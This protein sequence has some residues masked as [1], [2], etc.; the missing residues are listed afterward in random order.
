MH[1]VLR[2]FELRFASHCVHV[3]ACSLGAS[4]AAVPA[5]SRHHGASE[6]RGGQA[7]TDNHASTLG[8][9]G[10][11]DGAPA[12]VDG[13]LRAVGA[14][15][16][17][18]QSAGL[19]GVLLRRRGAKL[20]HGGRRSAHRVARRTFGRESH[21]A[22]HELSLGRGVFERPRERRAVVQRTG[23]RVARPAL[24]DLGVAESWNLPAD[25]G[26]AAGRARSNMCVR[27]R[28]RS[29]VWCSKRSLHCAMHAT[30][31]APAPSGGDAPSTLQ[32]NTLVSRVALLLMVL[33]AAGVWWCL[34]QPAGSLMQEHPRM[35]EVLA[36]V[37]VHRRHLIMSLTQLR[38]STPCG[39]GFGSR[40][41]RA[42]T[43]AASACTALGASFRQSGFGA[44]TAKPTWLY[45]NSARHLAAVAGRRSAT[46][47]QSTRLVKRY[48]DKRGRQRVVGLK[49]LK[50]SQS[51]PPAMAA[52]VAASFLE[53]RMEWQRETDAARS[54]AL[55]EWREV[56][57][58]ACRHIHPGPCAGGGARGRGGE[59]F[60]GRD[61]A[62]A[63]REGAG[64][65]YVPQL[66]RLRAAPTWV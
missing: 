8:C 30:M 47:P 23:G 13:D 2:A 50:Q 27:A 28:R 11:A 9:Y 58:E 19:R 40:G 21:P 33:E 29:R 55:C 14:P 57:P 16:E 24:R 60:A 59:D 66:Q 48:I 64:R 43:R 4:P 18:P 1:P 10:R 41:G 46:A 52:A 22:H 35:Q 5:P 49:A 53:H 51:Y 25:A 6:P 61:R 44:L 38:K 37:S 42:G 20:R 31:P 63:G 34:E 15:P 65:P 12:P 54:A 32:A 36:L 3:L 7:E 62:R 17:P 26:Y 45:S 56:P 39:A